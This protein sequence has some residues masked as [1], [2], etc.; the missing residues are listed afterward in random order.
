MSQEK[1]NG[2]CAK[3]SCTCGIIVL[4]VKRSRAACNGREHDTERVISMQ[5][6]PTGERC[7]RER[8][9]Y[10]GEKSYVVRVM[11][12]RRRFSLTSPTLEEAI[13]HR[14]VLEQRSVDAKRLRRKRI[15][16]GKHKTEVVYFVKAGEDGPIKVGRT[17]A[18]L[19]KTRLANLQIASPVELH[20]LGTLESD[21]KGE[22]EL[23]VRMDHLHVRGEWFRDAPELREVLTARPVWI[24]GSIVSHGRWPH[25]SKT[26]D[27]QEDLA[28]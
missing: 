16:A 6:N 13:E 18:D 8:I 5:D 19:V 10:K 14:G 1:A 15:A 3:T 25:D 24:R 28:A 21:S 23:H 22:R 20:L 27:L 11:V 26:F 2:V 7:I 9:N 12:G 17:R 4:K